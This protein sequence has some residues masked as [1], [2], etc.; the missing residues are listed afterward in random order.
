MGN[1]EWNYFWGGWWQGAS[2]ENKRKFLQDI[3]IVSFVEHSDENT[4][5]EILENA[6]YSLVLYLRPKL[7][8]RTRF[9]LLGRT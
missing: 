4:Q 7:K 1:I 3:D 8:L 5:L 9:K 6:P 2:S